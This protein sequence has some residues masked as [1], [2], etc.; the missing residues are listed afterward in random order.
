MEYNGLQYNG[1]EIT[2][3]EAKV[4]GGVEVSQAT[5]TDAKEAAG[6]AL[7]E[8]A[9]AFVND[10]PGPEEYRAPSDNFL[11]R[12]DIFQQIEAFTNGSRKSDMD[13]SIRAGRA[14]IHKA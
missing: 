14:Y 9:K 5:A 1:L 12:A 10:V 11:A 2:E 8:E 6:A 13:I 4:L 3:A 7:Y